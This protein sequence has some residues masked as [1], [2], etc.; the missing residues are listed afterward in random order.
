MNLPPFGAAGSTPDGD[1]VEG[2]MLTLARDGD[3]INMHWGASCSILDDDYSVYQGV[4]GDYG[5]HLPL[6]CSTGGLTTA[7][8]PTAGVSVYYLVAPRNPNF[9]GSLGGSSLAFER[10]IG[11]GACVP[12]L[13]GACQ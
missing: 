5:S 8:V 11:A 4:I 13:L 10:P 3:Q 12:Q 9:T 6:I 1:I 7:V 2:A